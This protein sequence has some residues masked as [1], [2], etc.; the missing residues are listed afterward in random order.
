MY[1][2]EGEAAVHK[3]WVEIQK[4]HTQPGLW[5]E[6]DYYEIKVYWKFNDKIDVYTMWTTTN[7]AIVEMNMTGVEYLNGHTE[8]S[9]NEFYSKKF[10]DFSSRQLRINTETHTRLYDCMVDWVNSISI[11]E[12]W[13]KHAH[14]VD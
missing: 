7:G 2:E 1:S 12:V 11:L 6:G 9:Y 8:A 10:P 4:V 13:P 3:K 14:D 5:K